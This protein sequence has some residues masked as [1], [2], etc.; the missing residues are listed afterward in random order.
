HCSACRALAPVLDSLAQKYAH[1]KIDV[2]FHGINGTRE[3]FEKWKSELNL[4][5][6]VALDP[7][8]VTRMNYA[9]YSLPSIYFIS[10]G[11]LVRYI[12]HGFRPA[13]EKILKKMFKERL[14]RMKLRK[15]GIH[16]DR[17]LVNV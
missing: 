17:D 13:D 6:P 10:S 8:D 3:E 12:H 2:I 14:K 4:S 7:A 11:G 1:A 5:L 16:P 9:V 15:K